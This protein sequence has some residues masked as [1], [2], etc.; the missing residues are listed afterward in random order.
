MRHKSWPFWE[1]WNVIFGKD[2][3]NGGEAEDVAE[4]AKRLRAQQSVGSQCNENDYHPSFENTPVNNADPLAYDADINDTGSGNDDKQTSTN[5]S[6]SLKRKNI[7]SDDKLM[8]FLGNPH[9][10]TNSRLEVIAARIRYEF[11]LGKMRQEVFN[12]LETVEG[13]TLDERYDLCQ[14]LGKESHSLEIFMGMP[15]NA[16]LGY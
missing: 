15:S 8:E 6:G 13:L 3:A 10:E 2:R 5:K 7:S 12:K 9:S 14:I 4:S 11:D 16:R 1:A